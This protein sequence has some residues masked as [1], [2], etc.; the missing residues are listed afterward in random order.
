MTVS[1]SVS[2][3]DLA[4]LLKCAVLSLRLRPQGGTVS[5]SRRKTCANMKGGQVLLPSPVDSAVSDSTS[6][7]SSIAI[8]AIAVIA[9]SATPA[10][11]VAAVMMVG[12]LAYPKG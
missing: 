4:G 6:A 11:A 3:G 1:D 10:V 12:L 9:V 7:Q 2:D 5:R 8:V